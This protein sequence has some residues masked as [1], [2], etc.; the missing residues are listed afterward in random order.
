MDPFHRG[1]VSP[2]PPQSRSKS[3]VGRR[4][5][6]FWPPGTQLI[7]EVPKT[8][9]SP[10]VLDEDSM[11]TN[12]KEQRKKTR[13][14]ERSL[15]QVQKGKSVPK[16]RLKMAIDRSRL[17]DTAKRKMQV[18]K[19]I[20]SPPAVIYPAEDTNNRLIEPI[21]DLD[22]SVEAT[23]AQRRMKLTEVEKGVKTKAFLK[24]ESEPT[25]MK[26]TRSKKS[27]LASPTEAIIPKEVKAVLASPEKR[28]KQQPPFQKLES[29]E[30]TKEATQSAE[31]P[32]KVAEHLTEKSVVNSAPWLPRPKEIRNRSQKVSQI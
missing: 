29:S 5:Q 28:E 30:T 2:V 23:P 20:T 17:V 18:K 15:H 1:S 22:A 14:K 13:E 25:P 24:L 32:D 19:K 9:A 31:G 11:K 7:R 21:E 10:V 3:R 4:S 26:A 12:S 6:S 27:H 16:K 8:P